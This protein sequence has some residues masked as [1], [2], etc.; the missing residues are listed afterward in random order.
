[1]GFV[2][3]AIRL[4]G[5]VAAFTGGAGHIGRATALA[6]AE[7]GADIVLIDRSDSALEEI[8]MSIGRTSGRKCIP[9]VADFT[10]EVATRDIVSTIQHK[11]NR[12]DILV[13]NVAFVGTRD[14][15]GWTVP[16]AR[17]SVDTWRKA[18]EVNLT[19]AFVLTQAAEPLLRKG[20]NGVVINIS[21]I[22]GMVGPDLDLYRGTDMGNP[23]AY[24]ASKGGLIQLTRWLATNLAPHIRVNTVTPGGLARNQPSEFIDRYI[25]RTPLRRMATEQDVV[26]A[27]AFLASD[28]SRYITGH[29]LV[30]DGGWTAW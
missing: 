10:N 2:T 28:L 7:L 17:Q 12:L 22:Y 20:G 15:P 3:D 24:A 13:N 26:G 21:S 1:M 18:I 29:N 11:L 9:I 25:A 16:F 30:V 5:R 19:S 8:A 27:I 14:L 6:L 4:D 23:A